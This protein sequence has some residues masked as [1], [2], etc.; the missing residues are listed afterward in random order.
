VN[1]DEMRN[2]IRTSSALAGRYEPEVDLSRATFSNLE[3]TF[4]VPQKKRGRPQK[5]ES[6]A[7][8][9]AA[10]RARQTERDAA[11]DKKQSDLQQIIRDI[12]T[13]LFNTD[14][15]DLSID[16][17]ETV[18]AA[19]AK[20]HP[21]H[22]GKIELI[23][24]QDERDAERTAKALDESAAAA[25]SGSSQSVFVRG[26]GNEGV[27]EAPLI[28]SEILKDSERESGRRVKPT[29]AGNRGNGSKDHDEKKQPVE[30]EYQSARKVGDFGA[31]KW[32]RPTNE[33]EEQ[34]REA[35]DDDRLSNMVGETFVDAR[36]FEAESR[37]PGESA[38]EHAQR[39]LD[40]EAGETTAW[41]C[42]ANHVWTGDVLN[43]AA[44]TFVAK[45]RAHAM[46]HLLDAHESRVK[47]YLK[48][49]TPRYWTASSAKRKKEK[50][51]TREERI[52]Q[53]QQAAEGKIIQS[54][55]VIA[56]Y[57]D[58]NGNIQRSRI[59]RS[60]A[61]RTRVV[62][63]AQIE[64]ESSLTREQIIE[65][66]K[67]QLADLENNVTQAQTDLARPVSLETFVDDKGFN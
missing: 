13:T 58:L 47:K 2:V 24:T 16:E 63:D 53:L 34:Q 14:V 38:S 54:D 65:H 17:L 61:E 60:D 10:Y 25:D 43:R 66:A 21:E 40:Y 3:I 9:Q 20:E 23:L 30:S 42:T 33:F 41:R 51:Q 32:Y 46:Q 50:P 37:L 5:H 11:E 6:A 15:N 36:T 39:M 56:V 52:Y 35:E 55:Y 26:R 57:H 45:R 59:L 12:A 1:V 19:V 7:D 67:Q 22:T 29:G 44:C 62:L 18:F 28:D 64:E 27:N 31:R 8:K 4:A 49:H 48:E